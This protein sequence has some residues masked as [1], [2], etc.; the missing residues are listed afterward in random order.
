MTTRNVPLKLIAAIGVGLL[1]FGFALF[2]R[3]LGS[4]GGFLAVCLLLTGT[5][6]VATA[7]VVAI[8]RAL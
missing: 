7:T 1:I 4:G 8:V 3:S 6:S 2:L 5:A